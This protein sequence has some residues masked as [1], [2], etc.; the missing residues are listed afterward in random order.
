VHGE[1]SHVL[2]RGLAV[3]D[4]GGLEV[5]ERGLEPGVGLGEQVLDPSGKGSR[6]LEQLAGVLR[7]RLGRIVDEQDDTEVGVLLQG[8]G[9]QRRARPPGRRG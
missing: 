5:V 6:L 1:V 2:D 4:L 7:A 9:E 8:G 3:A